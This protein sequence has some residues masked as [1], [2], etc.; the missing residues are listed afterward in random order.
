MPTYKFTCDNCGSVDVFEQSIKNKLPNECPH[1]QSSKYFQEFGTP[2]IVD[3]TPKTVG[4]FADKMSKE[5]GKDE[6]HERTQ[7]RK[8][9][10][11]LNK[12]NN[13]SIF[14]RPRKAA[15]PG[16]KPFW[17]SDEKVN[18][19]ELSRKKA[20]LKKFQESVDKQVYKD[21]NERG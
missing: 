7:K 2:F 8:E 9:Q 13:P 21:G 17:R 14:G 20:E 6:I 15:K 12:I 4:G 3:L 19:K 1:C 16:F 5:L 18:L 10:D 11:Y